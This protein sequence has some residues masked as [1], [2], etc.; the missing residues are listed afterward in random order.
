VTDEIAGSFM[1]NPTVYEGTY[2]EFLDFK[3][4]AWKAGFVR[5]EM[6][7]RPAHRNTVGYLHG[8]VIAS[9][10]DIAGAVAGSYGVADELVSVT[11][12]LNCN[13]MAP[14]TSDLV[15]AEGELVRTTNTLFFAQAK[16]LD[17]SNNRLCATATGTYKPQARE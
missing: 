16:L 1:D 14:H 7:V 15:I 17:P 5:I 10:L 12:N 3:L 4:V 8:G 13:Y 9:L 11:I 6:P 2:L